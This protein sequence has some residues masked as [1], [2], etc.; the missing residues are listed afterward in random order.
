VRQGEQPRD[1]AMPKALQAI[2]KATVAPYRY[3]RALAFRGRAAAAGEGGF[4]DGNNCQAVAIGP[5]HPIP[6]A[7]TLE[8]TFKCQYETAVENRTQHNRFLL[9]STYR[10]W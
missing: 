5:F 10:L 4:G 8:I 7:P 6:S 1:E 9:R 3:A 2:V